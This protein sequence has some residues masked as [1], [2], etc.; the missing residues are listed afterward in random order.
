MPREEPP[1]PAARPVARGLFAE[2]G[3]H[4]TSV[5]DIARAAPCS[6]AVL[7]LHFGGKLELFPR[8]WRSRPGGSA[9]AWSRRAADPGDPFAGIARALG[10]RIASRTCPTR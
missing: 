6:E 2:R 4:G 3:Y 1:G 8:C 7:Y 10:E 9:R 5:G